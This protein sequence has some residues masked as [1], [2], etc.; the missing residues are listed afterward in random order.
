VN[1]DTSTITLTFEEFERLPDHP[2]KR[3]LVKGE[4]LELPVAPYKYSR[5]AKQIYGRLKTALDRAHGGGEAAALGEV[6]V[7]MG[8]YLR[9]DGWLQPEGSISHAG[10][11]VGEYLEESP[12]IAVEVVLPEHPAE[13]MAVKLVEYFAH[14]AQEV[15]L[16]FPS[17]RQAHIYAGA[18]YRVVHESE[19]IT[20]ALLP[21][22]SLVLGDVL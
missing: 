12:A 1:M 6:F 14:G 22:F 4:L 15:W 13:P 10:Q 7:H 3:E 17:I 2:G 21:E 19:A 20:T 18:K 16:I 8:Y 11:V 9:P 5:A